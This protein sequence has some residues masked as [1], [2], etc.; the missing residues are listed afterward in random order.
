MEN[1][2]SGVVEFFRNADLYVACLA[3]AVLIIVTVVGVVARYLVNRPFGWMEEVQLW[4]FLWVVFLGAGAVARHGGHIAIDAFIGLFPQFLRKVSYGICQIVTIAVLGFFGYYAVHHVVL[5]YT[6]GRSTNI[7]SI[8]NWII[9]AVVPLS[10]LVLVLVAL[11]NLF[12]P[13]RDATAVEAAIKEV[14][15][16]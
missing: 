15:N 8:P 9:Y 10:C 11:I 3:L 1:K 7:L 4:A 16:V 6:S 14:E 5:M 12:R 13:R 2:R